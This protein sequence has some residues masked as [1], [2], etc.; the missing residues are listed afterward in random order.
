MLTADE[1]RERRSPERHLELTAMK[2]QRER[3]GRPL[4]DKSFVKMIDDLISRDLPPK[5]PGPKAGKKQAI[6]KPITRR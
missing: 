4:G 1:S 3:P 6:V 2:P 5:K